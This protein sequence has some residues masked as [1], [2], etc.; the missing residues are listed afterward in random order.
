CSCGYPGGIYP[1]GCSYWRGGKRVSTAELYLCIFG[2]FVVSY[3]PRAL[4]FVVL[5]NRPMPKFFERWLTYVPT[6]VF[7][8]LIFS[9]VFLDSNGVNFGLDNISMLASVPVLIVAAIKKSLPY[10]II[11]GLAAYGMLQYLM[12]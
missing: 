7:G 11:T 12:G 10:S 2:M 8:A 1:G 5:G 4:P 9:S 3:I 6:S